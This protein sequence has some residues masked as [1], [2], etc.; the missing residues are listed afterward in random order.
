LTGSSS[1]RDFHFYLMRSLFVGLAMVVLLCDAAYAVDGI[2]AMG[3][4]LR[5]DWSEAQGLPPG[6]VNAIAQTRDGYLW[7]GT[8]AGL[9]RFDGIRFEQMQAPADIVL[10][11]DHILGLTVDSKGALWIR[12]QGA[13]LVRYADNTYKQILS[14][15]DGET[16]VTAV[17]PASGEGVIASGISSGVS[18]VAVES[19]RHLSIPIPSLI[20]SLA[21]TTDGRI[22]LGTRETGLQ[23]W[24]NN[25]LIPITEGMPDR[26]INCL[27]PVPGNKL[28]IGTDNGLALWDGHA[29]TMIPLTAEMS[30]LQILA[31]VQDR[32][33]NL[34]AGTSRGLL[35]YN[36]LGAFW[37]PRNA[38]DRDTAVT[39]LLED[40]EGDLWFG[41]GANLERLR[42][43]AL[44]SYGDAEAEP[45]DRYGPAY[46]D[47]SGRVWFAPLAGGLYW[48]RA[49]VVHRVSQAGLDQDTVYSIDGQGSDI[50]LGRRQGGLTQLHANGD[51][52]TARTWT[53]AQGL[54]QDNVFAVRV[55]HDGSVW[56]GTVAAGASHLSGG[57]ITNFTA[58]DGLA[59]NT[60]NAIEEAADG[61]V[62]FATPEGVAV[63]RSSGWTHLTRREGLPSLD[64]I[65][66]LASPGGNMWVGTASGLAF[67]EN[68]RAHLLSLPDPLHEPVLGLAADREGQLWIAGTSHIVSIPLDALLANRVIP[69]G[70][71]NYGIQDGLRSTSVVRRSRSV[72]ADPSGRVWLATGS[73]LAVSSLGAHPYTVPAIAHVEGVTEDGEPV[74]MQGE[75]RISSG[76][77]RI[78]FNYAGIDLR[79]PEGVRYRYRLEGFD[80]AWS[81]PVESRQAVY[82]NLRPANYRFHVVAA[83]SD[84]KWSAEESVVSLNVEPMLWERW[85]FQFGFCCIVLLIVLWIY[86]ARMQ[87]LISQANIRFEERLIER[88]RIARE[89]HDTLLQ[90]FQGLILY[91]QTA[92]QK[93]SPEDPARAMLEE[94]LNYSDRVMVEGRDR[95]RNLRTN[96][97]EPTDLRE[98]L[99]SVGEELSK[100]YPTGFNITVE[101]EPRDLH[102]ILQEE[103]LQI[104]RE[105]LTNAFRHSSAE[106]VSATV[107]FGPDM[108]RVIVRDDGVGIAPEVLRTGSRYGHWGLPGMRERAKKIR[109][110]L[111]ITSSPDAGTSIELRIPGYVIYKADSSSSARTW[112]RRFT[113]ARG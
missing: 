61:S 59:S 98:T 48:M 42:D 58:A 6:R 56:A 22:W 23:V 46:A 110:Q 9:F 68:G 10:P 11:L 5:R 52:F 60:V 50:W 88:A 78:V 13:H 36:S 39:A 26:K 45:G 34:W 84:G 83:N 37:L 24:Q 113:T 105:A 96:M 25:K 108:L 47:A 75:A 101:G 51:E 90:G 49:D 97:T 87:H 57:R 95:V 109:A 32:D 35:R 4:Y 91:F 77:Q 12:T 30:H 1:F 31:M 63:M 21:Q 80:R 73:G 14:Q 72:V 92:T 43:T 79:A 99:S 107:A 8:D 7:V 69:E 67:A 64:A 40:R 111:F 41:N 66:L 20:I 27:L 76:S 15:K 38:H 55:A 2:R 19:I 71:R 103:V 106:K 33:G 74:S 104:S 102:P 28:W 86:H 18:M 82:T 29:A 54:A 62:W 53:H 16:A 100:V 3:Q 44:I 17:A 94:A 85:E 93:I 81:A 112:L 70:V 65:A 89:L